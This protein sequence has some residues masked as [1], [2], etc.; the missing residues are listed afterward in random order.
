M[1][2]GQNSVEVGSS[3]GMMPKATLPKLKVKAAAVPVI[4]AAVAPWNIKVTHAK[5]NV[6]GRK[7]NKT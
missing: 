7:Q 5:E 1:L 2:A 4:R 3:S 6:P